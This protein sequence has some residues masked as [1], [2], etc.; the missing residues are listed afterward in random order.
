VTVADMLEV[1]RIEIDSH[2]LASLALRLGCNEPP[3]DFSGELISQQVRCNKF[4]GRLD[5]PVLRAN[6]KMSKSY[7]EVPGT[8][9]CP[10]P[11][12]TPSG[13]SRPRDWGP[14]LVAPLPA[15]IMI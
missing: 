4:P 9:R 2:D 6:M 5:L 1:G 13:F 10:C 11:R 7:N 14:S 8:P 3:T 15:W 12:C